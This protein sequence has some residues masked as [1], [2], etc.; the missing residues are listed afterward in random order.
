MS[1]G[2]G[3]GRRLAAAAS[4][5]LLFLAAMIA[6]G[7]ADPVDSGNSVAADRPQ[8]L[9]TGKPAQ[10]AS[11]T[12]SNARPADKAARPWSLQDALPNNSSALRASKSE[13][14][15]KPGP[16]LGRVP[17]QSGAGSFGFETETKVD[18]NKLPD[19]QPVPGPESTSKQSPSYLGLSLSVPTDKLLVPQP[20]Q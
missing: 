6:V 14:A 20:A 19:G 7:V 17:L 11:R 4:G 5:T 2:V 16:G 18:P 12:T 10:P 8:A 15:P 13:V 9:R 1:L 3:N